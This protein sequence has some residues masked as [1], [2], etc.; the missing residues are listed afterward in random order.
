M[1]FFKGKTN[2]EKGSGFPDT[3]RGNTILQG[4][5]SN[6]LFTGNGEKVVAIKGDDYARAQVGLKEVKG[7][8]TAVKLRMGMVVDVEIGKGGEFC[9]NSLSRAGCYP[10][11][12]RTAYKAAA[13]K[14]RDYKQFTAHQQA[15]RDTIQEW[16]DCGLRET[17]VY[18]ANAEGHSIE[19]VEMAFAIVN[20]MAHISEH[21]WKQCSPERYNPRYYLNSALGPRLIAV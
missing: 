20:S 2:G 18:G 19:A 9:G 5:V 10:S 13:S 14:A 16:K 11:I 8:A 3:K 17:Q 7:A 12:V 21:Q 1:A 15:W 6:H 4:G